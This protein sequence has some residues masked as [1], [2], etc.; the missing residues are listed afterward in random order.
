MGGLFSSPPRQQ[1]AAAPPPPVVPKGPS[2]EE[3]AKQS[4]LDKQATSRRSASDV[5]N[6][7]GGAGVLGSSDLYAK[8]TL[9]GG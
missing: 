2:A 8:K 3:L 7:G 1:Q 9:L 4:L 5:T 6:I